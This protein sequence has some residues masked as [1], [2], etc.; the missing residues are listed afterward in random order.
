MIKMAVFCSGEGTNL[1]AIIDAVN[2]KKIKAQIALVVGDKKNALCL[3]RAKKAG[4]KTV[5]VDSAKFKNRET[6]D[7]KIIEF[8]E[9]AGVSLIV[10]AGFMRILS[11]YFVTKYKNRILN[12][13]PAILPS[14]K[15]AKGIKDAWDYGVKVTGVTVHFVESGIDKGPIILQEALK[16]S[17]KDT[18]KTLEAKIHKIEYKLYP[19]AIRLFGEKRLKIVGRKVK[20]LFV[21]LVVLSSCF[22]NFKDVF[23]EDRLWGQSYSS[24]PSY[25]KT[26][27]NVKVSSGKSVSNFQA[28]FFSEERDNEADTWRPLTEE[29]INLK[30]KELVYRSLKNAAELF[31]SIYMPY[32]SRTFLNIVSTAS[33]MDSYQEEIKEKHGL[34]ID[35]SLDDFEVQLIYEREY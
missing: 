30:K 2:K 33:A 10:L 15:G 24:L 25:L 12:I 6:F 19:E 26:M 23:A 22:I 28:S 29:E 18:L 14:F 21:L 11:S 20:I 1:K 13:H 27:K 3:R 32:A 16:I 17:K 7:K 34:S 9:E 31:D 35:V 5:F 8:L 4:F